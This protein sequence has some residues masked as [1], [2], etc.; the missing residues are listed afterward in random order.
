MVA[1][2]TVLRDAEPFLADNE[3]WDYVRRQVAIR[4]LERF[5]VG[6]REI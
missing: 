1:V 4:R 6:R 5:P 3:R 2:I